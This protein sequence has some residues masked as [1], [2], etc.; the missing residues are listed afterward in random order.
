MVR[1]EGT[2]RPVLAAESELP[3]ELRWQRRLALLQRA[4]LACDCRARPICDC[5]A[6]P[7]GD[8]R[9]RT[10]CDCRARPTCDCRACLAHRPCL[11]STWCPSPRRRRFTLNILAWPTSSGFDVA[12]KFD[13]AY[14]TYRRC[15]SPLVAPEKLNISCVQQA[16]GDL[17]EGQVDGGGPHVRLRL[18]GPDLLPHG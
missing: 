9:A 8:C 17:Q 2:A 16:A 10:A 6:R 11:L 18:H 12:Y 13:T 4:R 14:R 7:A 1:T 15:R 5:R 3:G